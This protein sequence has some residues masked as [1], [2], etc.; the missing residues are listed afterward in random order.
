MFFACEVVA[1]IARNRPAAARQIART[2]VIVVPAHDEASV[3]VPALRSLSD[4]LGE[5]MRILVVADNCSDD[6]AERARQAGHQVIERNDEQHRGKGFALAFAAAEL[7]SA[8]PDVVVVLDADCAIDSASLR[9]IV[10]EAAAS[11]RPCQAVNLIRT[12]LGGSPLVQIS[13]FAFFVKNAVRQRGLQRLAG[14]VHLTGTGMALPFAQFQRAGEVGGSVVEDLAFGIQLAESGYAP[15]LV[16]EAT[17]WSDGSSQAGTLIQ[18]RRWE[19]GFLS[20]S[21]HNGARL[22][23]RGIV[24]MNLRTMLAGLDLLIP[25]LALFA[26]VN[27]AVLAIAAGAAAAFDLSWWPIIAHGAALGA[28][29]CAVAA[30]WFGEGRKFISGSALL[31]I[32]L[33]VLWKL[34]LYAATARRGAPSEWL[35][36]GR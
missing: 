7:E 14:R 26:T 11:N 34:P 35:R 24:R 27:L 36:S 18:R 33:Y 30:S 9:A 12:C 10:D 15:W 2:A 21:F 19:G 1:G 16:D 17:V 4:A 22:V 28:A 32:P 29:V 5:G 8:P 25:P 13:T 3:I 20:L 31:R 23:G 6:T